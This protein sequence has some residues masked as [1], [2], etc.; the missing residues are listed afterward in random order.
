MDRREALE[1]ARSLAP[2][3]SAS[4]H[5]VYAAY[6]EGS[7]AVEASEASERSGVA[8]YSVP[9]GAIALTDAGNVWVRMEDDWQYYSRHDGVQYSRK[10]TEYILAY[11]PVVVGYVRPFSDVP[12]VGE[13]WTETAAEGSIALIGEG[14]SY[15]REAKGWCLFSR[16]DGYQYPVDP[17]DAISG[18]GA[19]FVGYVR[20]VN[21]F[22]GQYVLESNEE[23]YSVGTVALDKDMDVW[24]YIGGGKWNLHY[25]DEGES[26]LVEHSTSWVAA[27]NAIIV[28]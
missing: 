28:A 2:E 17:K 4:E 19:Q 5:V 20:N 8:L 23:Q 26:E 27:W 18:R 7:D 10:K 21:P 24:Y 3:A 12:V 11:N 13:D 22:V 14:Y 1:M 16:H 25:Y 9:M 6:L 15:V